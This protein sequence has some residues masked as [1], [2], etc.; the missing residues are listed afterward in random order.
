MYQTLEGFLAAP[1]GVPEIKSNEFERK[2]Q[3]VK[4][5][6]DGVYI[7]AITEIEDKY[8]LHIKVASESS[9]GHFYDVVILFFTDNDRVKK[10][11]SFRSYYVNFFSNSPSFIYQYATLYKENG[12]LIEML[13]DKMD[14]E[15]VDVKPTKVNISN[16]LSYDKSIYIACRFLQDHK[17]SGFSKAGFFARRRKKSDAF[18][19]DITGFKDAKF[20]QE[21]RQLDKKI[22]KQLK[23]S[24]DS[25]KEKPKK[26][27]THSSGKVRAK[28]STIKDVE[29]RGVKVVSRTGGGHVKPKKSKKH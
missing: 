6:K 10:D 2:Y 4:K 17:V 23:E 1:F 16:K 28:T 19:R 7:E 14:P 15:Y 18:F 26:I 8:L 24:P 12:M 27:N 25:K 13:Y 29:K 21:M 3:S 22:D 9:S 20:E 5:R 11:I